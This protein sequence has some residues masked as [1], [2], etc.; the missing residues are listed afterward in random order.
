MYT[1]FYQL[2]T[3]FVKVLQ[4]GPEQQELARKETNFFPAKCFL[5]VKAVTTAKVTAIPVAITDTKTVNRRDGRNPG[6][7]SSS[8]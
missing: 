7:R 1:G 5:K 8:R 2:R 4:G 3:D 6:L